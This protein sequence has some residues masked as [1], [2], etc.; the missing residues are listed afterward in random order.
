ML[1]SGG[2]HEVFGLFVLEYEP[3]AFHIVAGIAPVA[4]RGEISE[5]KFFLFALGDAGGGESDLAGYERLSAALAFMVEENA[6]AAEHAVC[7]AVFL[8][9]PVAVELG[10]GVWT[11]GMERSVFILRHLFHLAVEFGGRGLV[12]PASVGQA[13]ESH[14]LKDAQDSDGV[15]V[16]CEFRHVER[17]LHVALGCEIV[18]FVGTHFAYHLDEA[19]RV[20]KVGIVEMEIRITLEMGDPLAEIYGAAADHTMHVVAFLDQKFSEIR[21]VLTRNSS[22]ESGFHFSFYIV[23]GTWIRKRGL[24]MISRSQNFLAPM[25]LK[26]VSASILRSHSQERWRR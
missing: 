12:D 15:H 23:A 5:Q 9:Y 6:R 21:A 18:D 4:E 22:Y 20:G 26:N 10:H 13:A 24:I 14:C 11:V 7:L 17:Y 19:H 16:G 8:H 2:D 3:H 1:F 25:I